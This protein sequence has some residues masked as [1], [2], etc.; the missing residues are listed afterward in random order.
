[1]ISVESATT[2][3]PSTKTGTSGCPLTRSTSPRRQRAD[4][5]HLGAG[6]WRV[7]A[8]HD[9]TGRKPPEAADAEPSGSQSPAWSPDGGRVA[10]VNVGLGELWLMRADGSHRRP[11]VRG[12]Q[13]NGY[14]A[15]AWSPDGRRLAFI[16]GGP[17]G[18]QGIWVTGIQARRARRLTRNEDS[19]P[20]WSP[21]GR[22]IA[23]TR[24][25][26]GRYWDQDIYT[27]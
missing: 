16:V 18:N 1:M 24:G 25:W 3:L 9:A 26:K 4:R 12:L 6:E 7:R 13:V 19:S 5:V 2:R 8:L 27:V 20:A 10:F 22:R 14:E 11:L 15:P 23:F 17:K 21:D